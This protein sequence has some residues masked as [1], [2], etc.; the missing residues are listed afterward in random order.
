MSQPLPTGNF[1]WEKDLRQFLNIN[2]V[3]SN[4]DKGYILEVDLEYPAHLHNLHND[5]PLAPE[6]M[7][8]TENMLSPYAQ[9]LKEKLGRA[10]VGN[11]T[12]LIPNLYS[13]KNYV[14]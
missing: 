14:V 6:N 3:D 13:K 9:A 1:R 4:G 5:Y 8:V 12:K 10:K 11:T 7:V 2:N